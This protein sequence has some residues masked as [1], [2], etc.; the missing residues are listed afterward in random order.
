VVQLVQRLGL[1]EQLTSKTNLASGGGAL[2]EQVRNGTTELAFLTASE[3]APE[4]G[5]EVVGPLP[6]G[7]ES[8]TPFEAAVLVGSSRKEAAG[9]LVRFLSSSEANSVY[10]MHRM[11][12]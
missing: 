4:S 10:R 9:E 6:Q 8:V 5:V 11:D 3:I 12:P 1:S 2:N 7:I